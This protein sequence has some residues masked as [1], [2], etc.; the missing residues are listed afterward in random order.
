MST[1]EDIVTDAFRLL[2]ALDILDAEPS[3]A[4]MTAG[5]R[6]LSRMVD[7]WAADGLNIVTRTLTGNTTTGSAAVTDLSSTSQL[8][9]GLNVSGTGIPSARIQSID[10]TTQI[11]LDANV[12]SGG[13]PSITFTAIP[14]EAKYEKGVT[15]LLA[16]DLAPMMGITAPKRVVDMSKDG[17]A[18]LTANFIRTP[19]VIFDRDLLFTSIRRDSGVVTGN[20]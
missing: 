4:E 7:S 12:T 8:A 1:A 6:V 17:W 15:A 20:G 18:S 14:F 9:I 19:D 11:T 10:S 16:M 2:G 5:L 3:P 13:S